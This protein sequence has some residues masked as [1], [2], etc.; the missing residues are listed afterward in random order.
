[1][2]F[3]ILEKEYWFGGSINQGHQMPYGRTS[4]DVMDLFG[5]RE[6]DQF[7]P[8]M[9]STAGRYYWN[10]KPYRARIS[11]GEI[12][13]EA[14]GG[15]LCGGFGDLRGA[16]RAAMTAH[17]PFTGTLPDRAF[18]TSPQYN[19]WME[20]GVDQTTER[21]LAY[22]EGIVAHGLRPGVLMID[23]GW[24][25]DYGVYE[26]FNQRK[27]SD[28]KALID[29]LHA[30][31]FRV[32]LW[33]SPIVSSAGWR[34]KELRTQKFLCADRAG[35]PV[36]R[37]WWS[38]TS[39]V[40]D[41]TNPACAAWFHEK[42]KYAMDTYGVDGF[43]FDAGDAYFYADDD[44]IYQPMSAREQTAAFNAFGA[45]Y[46][47]NEF[48]AAWKFGG[49]PIVARLH[50]KYHS[51]D[52]FGLNT[53]IPHTVAQGLAGYAY[54]CPDM[55]GG[56]MIS[57][58]DK[59]FDPELFVRWTEANA[60]MAMMQLSAAPWRVLPAEYYGIVRK[61]IRLHESFGAQIYA[62]AQHAAQTGEPIVRH[63]SYEFPG[64]GFETCGDQFML[65]S[66]VLSAPVLVCGARSR[67]VRLPMGQWRSDRGEVL[68][69]GRTIA[70]DAPLDRLPY[71]VRVR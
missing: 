55:V 68:D 32:M 40:M 52:H 56:G 65:G 30:L 14:D 66:D 53:L 31:G 7:A 24:Q 23:G 17:F 28:P 18:F 63:M 6:N 64:E 15:E 5:G 45:A 33:V 25:E 62:L 49:Q 22:A 54:C 36:L 71:F 39:C 61:Y 38:G 26:Y 1:M 19:T 51:W 35:N 69:G 34:F 67:S 70:V 4:D 44:A 43:K 59:A 2:K 3:T 58:A 9:V 47:F 57:D 11:G 27:I 50:D 20:L 12:E 37:K 8:I 48:R 60:L 29:R 42:L 10:D 16:Y 21:I 13:I 41:L 46:S